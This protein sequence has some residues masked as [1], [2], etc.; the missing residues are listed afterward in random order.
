[1][2]NM[3][4]TMKVGVSVAVALVSAVAGMG[5]AWGVY[6]GKLTTLEQQAQEERRLNQQQEI[7]LT[8]IETQ[9][10]EIIRRLDRIESNTRK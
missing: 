2:N 6:S 10:D 5:S 9:Y 7:A 4:T 3:D 1:M 8:K